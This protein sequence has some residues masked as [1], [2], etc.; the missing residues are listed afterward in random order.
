MKIDKYLTNEISLTVT[1]DEAFKIKSASEHEVAHVISSSNSDL[2][3][4]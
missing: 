4:H 2:I 1:I 3:I